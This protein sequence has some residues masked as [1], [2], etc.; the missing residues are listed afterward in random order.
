MESTGGVMGTVPY[1]SPEQLSGR[2]VDARTDIF[3]FGS[4][5]FEMLSGTPAFRRERNEDTIA[6]ILNDE[7]DWSHLRPV[8]RPLVERCLAK[9]LKDRYES[10]DKIAKALAAV[11][12]PAMSEDLI[13]SRRISAKRSTEPTDPSEVDTTDYSQLVTEPLAP[14]RVIEAADPIRSGSEAAGPGEEPLSYKVT[15]IYERPWANRLV[16]LTLAIGAIV[17]SSAVFG[18]YQYLAENT[19]N[20]ENVIAPRRLYWELSYN[21]RRDFIRNGVVQIQTLIGDVPRAI[22]NDSLNL[23]LKEVDRYASRRDSLSQEPLKD[24]LRTVYGRASQYVPMVSAEF[25]KENVPPA[26]GIYQAIIESEYRDCLKSDTGPIG[27]FQFSKRTAQKYGLDPNDRC[28]VDLSAKAA[29][30][31]ISHLLTYF[32]SE[33]SSRTLAVL[34]FNQGEELTTIQLRKLNEL[35]L[36]E[37]NYWVISENQDRF[38]FYNPTTDEY[39][40]RFFAAAIIG[41]NPEVF[42]LVTPSLSTIKTRADLSVRS[43]LAAI[44]GGTFNMGRNDS[45]QENEKP[46]HAVAVDGFRMARNEVTNIEFYE[47]IYATGYGADRSKS[48]FLSHWVHGRPMDFDENTPVRFVNI[49]DINAFIAWKSQKDGVE[50]RL[51]TEQ[52]WEY[53]ARNGSNDN[54]YPWGDEFDARCAV[55]DQQY[56]EPVAVGTRTCPNAWGIRDLIGNVFEWTSTTANLYPGSL[57][58]ILN[59][60]EPHYMIR[61]GSALQRSTGSNAITS[62][63]RVAI[64]ESRRSP[65]LGFRLVAAP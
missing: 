22:S 7:P 63:F 49:E 50:Y 51:P 64:P 2:A 57:G 24:G 32:G 36:N 44:P 25:K 56:N 65:E 37:R 8:F 18:Y 11:R 52:E 23:I 12:K 14:R 27:I 21:D 15:P 46:E 6:A 4:L 19:T 38:S 39:V 30:A 58:E 1:M 61:G 29:A 9:D 60:S 28:R 16:I 31:Y 59:T 53:A 3:S 62:T 33:S 41:E 54:L 55:L 42:D 5:L 34:S 17:L 35:G 40:S 26:I 10:A 45:V 47:F 20:N 13:G 43:D 48:K